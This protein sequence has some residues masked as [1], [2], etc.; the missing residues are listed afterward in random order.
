MVYGD[1]EQQ[2]AA[3]DFQVVNLDVEDPRENLFS[4]E[5]E[6][7]EDADADYD[8][9]VKGLSALTCRDVLADVEHDGDI[10][11]RVGDSEQSQDCLDISHVWSVFMILSRFNYR[12]ICKEYLRAE[13]EQIYHSGAAFFFTARV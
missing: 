12:M 6:Y 7:Y 8:G 9:G 1:D 5:G 4:S 13:E 3:G 10:S 2:N 11:N